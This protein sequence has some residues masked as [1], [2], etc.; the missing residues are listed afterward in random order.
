[1]A[2]L[3]FQKGYESIVLAV[4]EVEVG[5]VE[6]TMLWALR[7]AGDEVGDVGEFGGIVKVDEVGLDLA[8]AHEVDASEEDA[9]DVEEGFDVGRGFFLEELPLGGG[10][11]QI[12]VGVMAS[13]ALWVHCGA[14]DFSSSCSGV[15]WTTSGERSCSRT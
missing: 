6:E 1:L 4:V 11:A 9:V 14:M 12:V 7:F 3:L 13:D 15:E 2:G 10:E 5:G 8:S